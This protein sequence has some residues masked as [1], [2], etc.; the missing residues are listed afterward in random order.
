MNKRAQ[1]H[2]YHPTIRHRL[3]YAVL[4]RFPLR[5]W[6]HLPQSTRDWWAKESQ[7]RRGWSP[8]GRMK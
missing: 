8:M 7:M 3:K 2:P 5:F 6:W 4:T 1:A